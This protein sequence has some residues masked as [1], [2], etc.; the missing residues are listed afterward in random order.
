LDTGKKVNPFVALN[1][2]P[3]KIRERKRFSAERSFVPESA[4]SKLLSCFVLTQN[5]YL[6]TKNISLWHT[7]KAAYLKEI[8]LQIQ[9]KASQQKQIL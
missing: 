7:N 3:E 9:K 2:N 4:R 6:T 8:S 1:R 5:N